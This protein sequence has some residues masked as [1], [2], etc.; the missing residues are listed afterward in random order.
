MSFSCRRHSGTSPKMRPLRQKLQFSPSDGEDEPAEEDGNSTGADSAFQELDSPVQSRQISGKERSEQ[1]GGSPEIRDEDRDFWEEE[2]FGSP[3]PLKSPSDFMRGSPS[4]RKCNRAYNSFS[5]ESSYHREEREGSSSPIPDCPDTPPHKTFRKLRLFD[6]PHTPKSLLSKAR[7][8]SGPGSVRLRGVALFKNRESSGKTSSDCKRN[9]TPHV[10]I[11]PFTPDSDFIQSATLQRNNRK[12]THWNDSCGEDM[13]ASDGEFEDETIPPPKRITIT[14][15]NM[16]SRY[17]TEFHELEKI[18][19]GEFGS[20]FK[21]VKRLDGCIY[22]I[23]RSKKPLAGS[24]DEKTVPSVDEC[25]DDDG[26]STSVIYKIGDLGHV[27]RVS[28]PKVEEGDSRFLANEVLQ[29]DYRNLTKADIFALALTVISAAG[30]ESMP[31]NGDKWHDIRQGKLPRIPQL[32]I[33]QDPE[34][35]PSASALGKHPVLLTAA[36]M[37]AEQ[38]R[39]E[40]NAEKFKN[41]LLQKKQTF[42]GRQKESCVKSQL[43]K[44]YKMGLREELLKSIWHAF[45]ALDVDKSGKVSKSQLKVLS[46]NLCTVLNVPH[47]PVALEEHF[48][49]DDEGPVSNQG[50]MPYLNKFIL[51]KVQDNFN[52][53]DF[54]RMCW[55]LCARKNLTKNTLLITDDDA[56]KI[57]CIFNFL[58]EDKYPLTLVTEEIEYLLK[59]LT[60]A[61]GGIWIEEKFEDY[62]IQL[63]AKQQCLSVWELIELIG[64][65]HFSKGMD[66]QTLS[67]GINEVFQ[68]LILDVLKQGYMMKK[69]H[70]RKNWT[71]RWF[72]LKPNVLSYFVNENLTEKKGHVMLDGSCCVESLPDKEGKKCL[73]LIKCSGKSFEISASDKKKKQEWIQAVQTAVNLLKQGL[74]A[75]HKE[76]RQKRKELRQKLQAEQEALEQ[77]M[78][79]LQ[80]ANESKQQ[81]LETMRKKLQ[82]D[83]ASAAEEARRRQQTQTELHDRYRT[84]LEREK[85]VRQ[86]MEE[87]VAQK[88]SELEQYLQR[89]RELEDMYRRLEESLE[90]ERQARQDEE[91]VRKLQARLLEEEATKRAELEHLHL[92]QQK[93]ISRTEA[94]KQELEQQRIVKEQALQA[95]MLQLGQLESER[96]E[97]LEQ[98]E[99]QKVHN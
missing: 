26:L 92:Q 43:T 37:S 48:K 49:D 62:K 97:A 28:N 45:T 20:V 2:G 76:A 57:W 70:R 95:A 74:P 75:P 32:M 51:D 6:T 54:N 23:K 3:S 73:F 93:A 15:S 34:K 64:T 12:R 82:E 55:T 35:R 56:F 85:M 91:T 40:L 78:K 83:E 77:R 33:H 4:P 65:G 27:T 25:D 63:N 22:A 42:S 94:E 90:D 38:L 39:I 47:D 60:E 21:C 88:S 72:V 81:E 59:K 18:G 53:L 66:R 80:T 13:E 96:K 16:K 89:V 79:E 36:R 41:A 1:T 67:M 10:N 29:E 17:A 71:E 5:P 69:G 50:Y 58:T 30:A 8:S 87:E 24:V 68:E 52:G 11:N 99:V 46:H 7:A 61:M 14:E 19:S 44:L 31:T 84:D 86:Q 9:T 98:Y